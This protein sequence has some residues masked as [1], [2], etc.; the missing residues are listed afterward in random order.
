MRITQH[1]S[2][3]GGECHGESQSLGVAS[4]GQADDVLL[5]MTDYGSC[6]MV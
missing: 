5:R 6:V 4:R 1:S 3:N 2:N